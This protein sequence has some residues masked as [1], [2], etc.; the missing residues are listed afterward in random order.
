MVKM[1]AAKWATLVAIA[2]TLGCQRDPAPPPA[3]H[4]PA[5]VVAPS[6]APEASSA[7]FASAPAEGRPP[8]DA[9][10]FSRLFR[11]LS[12][13]DQYFFSDNFVSNETSY[14]QVAPALAS[15][16]APGGAY[17]GVGPEQNFS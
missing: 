7:P 4:D 16:A 17:L 6:A 1:T 14:L 11:E 10:T 15:R 13:P 5:P 8:L 12:E 3:R 2:M 9:T